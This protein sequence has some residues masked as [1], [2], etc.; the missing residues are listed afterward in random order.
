MQKGLQIPA[1]QSKELLYKLSMSNW[2]PEMANTSKSVADVMALAGVYKPND[3]TITLTFQVIRDLLQVTGPI[4]VGNLGDVSADNM[5]EKIGVLHAQSIPGSQEKTK[6]VTDFLPKLLEKMAQSDIE[7]KQQLLNVFMQAVAQ[8][9][10]M[11]YSANTQV[12]EKLLKKY[13]TYRTLSVEQKPLMA[14][15]WNWGGNKANRYTKRVTDLE[16]NEQT[17]RATLAMTYTNES[18]IDVYP[19]GNYVNVQR[20][21]YPRELTFVTATGYSTAP[22]VYKTSGGVPYVMA[23]LRVN[24]Q[25]TKAALLNFSFK[26]LPKKLSLYKQSGI[27]VEIFRVT[28]NRAA[29][30]A[31]DETL[32]RDQEFTELNGKWFKTYVRKEDVTVILSK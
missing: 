5:Y 3:V 6:V 28:I 7:Q 22:T 17:G 8:K 14:V 4:E 2:D 16:I 25:Q 30:S 18:K 32:L 1:N 24:I 10:I 13:D 23:E 19:Q 20:V 27:D 26:E 9:T 12:Q 21:Y 15:D 31:I 11:V 29:N